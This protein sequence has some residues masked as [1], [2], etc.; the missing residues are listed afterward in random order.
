MSTAAL[1]GSSILTFYYTAFGIDSKNVTHLWV[2]AFAC[3]QGV[4]PEL[5]AAEKSVGYLVVRTCRGEIP[6]TPWGILI[7]ACGCV[8]GESLFIFPQGIDTRRLRQG[9]PVSIHP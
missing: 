1:G 2:K 4:G 5:E 8:G 6:A 3:L 9:Q 7:G